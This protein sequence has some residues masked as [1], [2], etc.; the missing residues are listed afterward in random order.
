M[1]EVTTAPDETQDTPN[2]AGPEGTPGTDQGIDYEKRYS[3]LR[4]EFDR[5]KQQLAQYEEL[6]TGLSSDDPDTR[7]R[8]AQALGLEFVQ[9]D[10][11]DT[12]DETANPLETRLEALERQLAEQAAAVEQQQFLERAQAHV[13]AQ[14]QA[15][16]DLEEADKEW[17]IARALELPADP[18]GLPDIQ[19]A[20]QALRD[21]QTELQKRWVSSKKAPHVSPVGSQA[22]STPNLDDPNERRAYMAEMLEAANRG[23]GD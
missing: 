18:N 21:Y 11:E 12:P 13:D 2:V 7:A 19:A 15:L 1:E 5:T 14:F 4:P 23:V 6:V 3:D 22:T 8:A 20:H 9:D 17:V 10:V 16:P